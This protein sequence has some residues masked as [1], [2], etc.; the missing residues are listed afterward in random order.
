M[1]GIQARDL[2]LRLSH[3]LYHRLA[4]LSK[5]GLEGLGGSGLAKYEFLEAWE[6]F[7]LAKYEFLDAWE[8]FGLDKYE[9]WKA[10]RLGIW[11]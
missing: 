4:L 5:S 1:G 2:G 9:L 3:L 10:S 7:G 11:N 6:A 8:A